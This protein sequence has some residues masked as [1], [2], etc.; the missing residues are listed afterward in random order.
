[1]PF[2]QR[3]SPTTDDRFYWQQNLVLI[4]PRTSA[5]LPSVHSTWVL[6]WRAR[7]KAGDDCS[8]PR[9]ML[10]VS[11]TLKTSALWV[12]KSV[13]WPSKYAIMRFRPGSTPPD[14]TYAA[15]SG[16]LNWHAHCGSHLGH[17]II[18]TWRP[19]WFAL[20]LYLRF[21]R[22]KQAIT[23]LHRIQKNTT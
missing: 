20:M 4:S 6:I 1:M 11:R 9:P 8:K 5:G 7:V 14:I 10:S 12:Y 17:P 22:R 21:F 23:E 19:L 13:L 3:L 15:H 18:W 16:Q 2:Y